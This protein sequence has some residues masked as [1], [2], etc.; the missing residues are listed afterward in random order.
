MIHFITEWITANA[1]QAGIGA[2]IS[3]LGLFWGG[4]ALWGKFAK[5][6]IG[7]GMATAKALSESSPGGRKITAGE[8]KSLGKEYKDVVEAGMEVY[9]SVRKKKTK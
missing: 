5:E 2:L 1:I 7:A 6:T 8:M 4:A 3:I 9:V